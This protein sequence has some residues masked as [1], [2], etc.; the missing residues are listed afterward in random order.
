MAWGGGVLDRRE[1]NVESSAMGENLDR[2]SESK[3]GQ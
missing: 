3:L 2:P 1:I